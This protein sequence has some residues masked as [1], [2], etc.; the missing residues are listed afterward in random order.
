MDTT[1]V[2][3]IAFGTNRARLQ[4]TINRV[5]DLFLSKGQLYYIYFD[6]ITCSTSPSAKR[7]IPVIN[8]LYNTHHTHLLGYDQASQHQFTPSAITILPSANLAASASSS[9][10][11][12]SSG[13]RRRAQSNAAGI[14]N[15][16]GIADTSNDSAY[17]LYTDRK[18]QAHNPEPIHIDH[19]MSLSRSPSPQRKGGWSTPGLSTPRRSPKP[20]NM[21]NG[22]DV[23]W[24]SAQAR[25]A[26]VNGYPKQNNGYGFGFIGRHMRNFSASLPTF[27]HQDDDRYMEKEKARGGW[28]A[29]NNTSVK[30]MLNRFGRMI[31]RLRLRVIPLLALSILAMV[32][33]FSREWTIHPFATLF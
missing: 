27:N 18:S 31:W 14:Y 13:T 2:S 28:R 1:V 23:T 11:N 19:H 12:P 4:D 22:H 16:S 30:G 10:D 24:A 25:S 29:A 21:N 3:I 33:F 7:W 5:Y 6:T 26:Q 17:P 15:G 9:S 20:Y 8:V 32:F